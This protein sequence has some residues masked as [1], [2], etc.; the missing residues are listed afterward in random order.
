MRKKAPLTF[1]WGT[2]VYNDDALIAYRTVDITFEPVT[3][4]YA[5]YNSSK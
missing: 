2:I 1:D 5:K 3:M 4:Q